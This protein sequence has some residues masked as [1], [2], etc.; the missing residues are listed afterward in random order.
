M[1]EQA[2]QLPPLDCAGCQGLLQDYLDETLPKQESLR[3]FLH[4]RACPECQA[5]F[6]E[7]QAVF[8]LLDGLPRHEPPADFDRRVLSNVP[9]AGYRAMEP[10]RRERVPVYLTEGFM[11]RFLRAGVTRGGGLAIA[12][13]GAV[14]A[15]AGWWPGAVGV[16]AFVGCLPEVLV[17]LQAAGRRR[18]VGQRRT[19]S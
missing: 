13:L 5:K 9:Y 3:A 17:R 16:G 11:P 19:G 7:A 6:A 2:K 12:V 1:G 10:L 15:A 8:A 14:G 18:L 4:L